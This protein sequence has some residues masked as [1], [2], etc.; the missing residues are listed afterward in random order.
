MVA[1]VNHWNAYPRCGPSPSSIGLHGTGTV[2]SCS[3]A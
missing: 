2:P 1:K 3:G